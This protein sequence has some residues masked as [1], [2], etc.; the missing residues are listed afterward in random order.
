MNLINFDEGELPFEDL[1]TIGLASRGQLLLNPGDLKALLSGRRT[2]LLHLQNLEAK[3]IRIK[4]IDAKIS[5]QRNEFGKTRLLIHPIYRKPA[6]PD[7]LEDNEAHQLEKG[8]VASLLK[9]TTDQIGNKKD[10][11]V[12]YDPETREFIVSDTEKILAPDMVNSEFLT[13]GQKENYRKGKE[14]EIADKTTL[15]YSGTDVH[16]IRS[17]RLALVASLLVDG[18]LSYMVYQGLNAAFGKEHNSPE[19][20]EL[21]PGY[22]AAIEDLEDQRPFDDNQHIRFGYNRGGR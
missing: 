21:S 6:T 14:V 16:G 15:T 3:N 18:G 7:F 8:E 9:V 12:E 10:V 19:A 1:E 17:N 22:H 11:L 4:A 2:A 20:E 13:A 5:L